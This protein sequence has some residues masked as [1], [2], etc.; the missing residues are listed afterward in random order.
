MD[1]NANNELYQAVLEKAHKEGD[2]L[3]L[4]CAA[5]FSIA[6]K[7]GVNIADVGQACNDQGIKIA[8]C[9]LGCF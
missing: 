9:Q 5:A 1:K 3:R 2:S 8:K 7:R 4:Q 6:S